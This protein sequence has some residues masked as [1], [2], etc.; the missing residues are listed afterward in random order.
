MLQLN[1]LVCANVEENGKKVAKTAA[2]KKTYFNYGP[3]DKTVEREKQF[4]GS[5]IGKVTVPDGDTKADVN[6]LFTEMLAFFHAK[7]PKTDPKVTVLDLVTSAYDISERAPIAVG[8]KPAKALDENKVF[9]TSAKQ[10]AAIGG[11]ID[12]TSGEK[13]TDVNS[14]IAV[15]RAMSGK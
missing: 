14:I 15:L 6:H 8:L 9:E 7:Y 11:I 1:D 4:N 3:E 12:P 2:F 10:M 13:V 5:V